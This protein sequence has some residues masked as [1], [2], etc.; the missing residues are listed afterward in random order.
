MLISPAPPPAGSPTRQT[1]AEKLTQQLQLTRDSLVIEVACNDG[2]L[3]KNFVA[4]GIPC[5][6]HRTHGQHRPPL[7]SR[8]GIPVLCEFFGEQLGKQL[9]A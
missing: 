1:Y 4:A 5:L 8:R 9:A 3:L 2:Y 6:G 7:P